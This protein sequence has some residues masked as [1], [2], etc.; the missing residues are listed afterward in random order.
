MGAIRPPL[1]LEV[2]WNSRAGPATPLDAVHSRLTPCKMMAVAPEDSVSRETHEDV[3]D[4]TRRTRL[5]VERTYLAW[6]RSAL[7]A[8][9]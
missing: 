2:G 3:V 9:A 8:F 5:A 7:T 4:A 6:W 1:S